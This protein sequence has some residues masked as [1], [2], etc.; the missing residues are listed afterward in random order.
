[1]PI[2]SSTPV[3]PSLIAVETFSGSSGSTISSSAGEYPVDIEE[4]RTGLNVK[5]PVVP[6]ASIAL[7]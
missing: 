2:T 3:I 4:S 5:S 1:M 7:S 6:S